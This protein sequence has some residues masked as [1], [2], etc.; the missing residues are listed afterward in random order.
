MTSRSLQRM[1]GLWSTGEETLRVLAFL[2]LVKVCRH[3]KDTFLSPV[4]KVGWAGG[5]HLW[6]PQ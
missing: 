2:V 4:L 3:Q 5:S 1:V 6:C